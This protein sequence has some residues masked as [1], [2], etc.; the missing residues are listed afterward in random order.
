MLKLDHV[1]LNVQNLDRAI[2]WYKTI[3]FKLKYSDETWASLESG[4]CKLALTISSEHPPHLAFRVMSLKDFPDGEIREH[5]DGSK[6]LYC[7][8]SEGNTIEWIYWPETEKALDWDGGYH[9]P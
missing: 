6:Y 2:E 5:R 8:D 4:S 3:G 1:A 7:K 9:L